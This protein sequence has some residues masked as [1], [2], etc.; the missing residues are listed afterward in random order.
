MFFHIICLLPSP[1]IQALTDNT[2]FEIQALKNQHPRPEKTAPSHSESSV[3]C[4]HEKTHSGVTAGSDPAALYCSLDPMIC[5]W[6]MVQKMHFPPP[7]IC[8][9]AVCRID[10]AVWDVTMQQLQPPPASLRPSVPP[11]TPA[12]SLVRRVCSDAEPP[13][14]QKISDGAQS[15]ET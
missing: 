11:F 13:C 15:L 7:H 1:R 10:L 8:V 5:R 9:L 6:L 12:L 2:S 3:V 14:T 4:T